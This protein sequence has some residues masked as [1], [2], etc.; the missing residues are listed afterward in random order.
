[1]ILFTDFERQRYWQNEIY[2]RLDLLRR[3]YPCL[4][5][6]GLA[7]GAMIALRPKPTVDRRALYYLIVKTYAN[8]TYCLMR[9]MMLRLV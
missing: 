9:L 2:D 3:L 4:A 7:G 8:G 5:G 1:M 6:A